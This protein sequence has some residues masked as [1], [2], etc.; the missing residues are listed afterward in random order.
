MRVYGSR[1]DTALEERRGVVIGVMDRREFNLKGRH[2][3]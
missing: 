3:A 2:E 1:R